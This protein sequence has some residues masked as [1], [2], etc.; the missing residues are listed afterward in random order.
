MRYDELAEELPVIC[1]PHQDGGIPLSAFRNGTT[2]KLAGLFC[3][4]NTERQAGKL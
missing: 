4:F 3:P 1:L 2:I